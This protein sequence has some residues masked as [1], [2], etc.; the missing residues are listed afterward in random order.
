MLM[1]NS[2]RERRPVEAARRIGCLTCI[3]HPHPG[4]LSRLIVGE[5]VR[6]LRRSGVAGLT[7]LLLGLAFSCGVVHAT[8]I[9]VTNADNGRKL[10][11]VRGDIL[12]VA[13]PSTPGT[14]FGW[15]VAHIDRDVLRASGKPQLIRSS[16][17]MPGAPATQVFRFDAARRG[18]TRL[19][20]VYVRP[21]ERGVAPARAFRLLVKVR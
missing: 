14:G 12:V 18:S 4:P 9:T 6:E 19:D 7:A 17:P 10:T 16:K 21:W 20:L 8:S 15:Q 1:L 5:G 11:L 2:E 3:R 13:L